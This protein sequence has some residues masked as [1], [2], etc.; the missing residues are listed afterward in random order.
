MKKFLIINFVIIFLFFVCAELVARIFTVPASFDFIERRIMEEGLSIKKEP[1]EYRILLFGESTMHGNHLFPK[2]TIR[3]WMQLYLENLLGKE[4]AKHIKIINLGR[5]GAGSDFIK[6]SYL[7]TL[8]YK[9][10]LVIFYTAHNDFI[11]LENR[12]LILKKVKTNPIGDFFQSM[13]KKSYFISAMKRMGIKAKLKRTL[14]KEAKCDK[15]NDWYNEKKTKVYHKDTD[16]LKPNGPD[17][18]RIQSHWENNIKEIINVAAQHHIQVMFLE[19]I[20]K[21][22]EYEPFESVHNHKL[23]SPQ[24]LEWKQAFEMAETQLKNGQYVEAADSYQK[25]MAIDPQYALTYFRLGECYEKLEDY[26]KANEFYIASNERDYFPVRAPQTANQFYEKIAS[27]HLPNVN[28]IK[29]QEL[30]ENNSDHEIVDDSLIL[31]QIH[32]TMKG[33]ALIALNIVRL[34]YAQGKFAPKIEWHWDSLKTMDELKQELKLDNNFEFLFYIYSANYVGSYHNKAVEYLNEALARKPNAIAAKSHLA[35]IYW[36]TGEEAKAIT[37][38]K[39]LYQQD[40]KKAEKFFKRHP[41]I[42]QKVNP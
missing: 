9:P 2:S 10:D 13:F 6:Q 33:Q 23:S 42:A 39:E 26:Q 1:G 40:S 25:A 19:G 31:D 36:T 7:D 5:L 22:R 11:Q 37:I 14:A 41:E 12:Q 20:A 35:W 27:S 38:Y 17:F 30:F 16:L 18:Q 34:L 29:T 28:V 21:Y 32:P 4:K 15:T 24:M 8:P 3:I